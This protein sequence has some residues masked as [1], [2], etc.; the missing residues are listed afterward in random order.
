MS[1]TTV[2]MI[3]A[4]FLM[5]SS[6]FF[7]KHLLKFKVPRVNCWLPLGCVLLGIGV[8][9]NLRNFDE[10][11]LFF[12]AAV[13]QFSAYV[14][15]SR[16]RQRGSFFW[17]VMAAL[18][19]NSA[20]YATMHILNKSQAYWMLFIPYIIGLVAGRISGVVWAQYIE[21]KFQLKA[22]AT[23]DDRLAP[24][25]RL[26]FL[27]KEWTF[28]TLIVSLVFYTIYGFFGFDSAM[29]KSLLIVIG[30]GVL[31]NFFYAV[32]TRA[33]ARGNNWYIAA[34]GILSG[35][36]FYINAVYLFSHNM[37]WA[38]V[39]PYVLSTVL[40]SDGTKVVEV[41]LRD[42]A[43]NSVFVKLDPFILDQTVPTGSLELILKTS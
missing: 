37:P 22:D 14:F 29:F 9:A 33:S 26:N 8:S 30:L 36:T 17:H 10:A 6:G 4:L 32:N 11:I 31:Q 40:G 18:A 27:A 7:L 16:L 15:V 38:L 20:W 39:V 3:F 41:G 28:W 23:R 5:S 13:A 34:T 2:L 42:L 19:S 24:G 1:Q 35:I 25:K 12:L 21:Q 43:G